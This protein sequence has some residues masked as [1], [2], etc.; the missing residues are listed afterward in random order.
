[1]QLYHTLFCRCPKIGIQPFSKTLCDLAGVPFK[2]YMATQL[3]TAFDVYCSLLQGVRDRVNVVLGRGE[4][5]WRMLNSC[6]SCQYRLKED[7]PLEIRMIVEMD[8]NDSLRRVERR[9]DS[10]LE[11][12]KEGEEEDTPR[13]GPLK[14]RPDHRVGGGSYFLSRHEVDVWDKDNWEDV[15]QVEQPHDHQKTP[16]EMLWEDGRCEERWNNMK[17][18]NTSRS[19]GRFYEWGWFILLCR[20]MFLLVACDMIRSGEQYV[21]FF[22]FTLTSTNRFIRSKY[23]LACLHKYMSAEKAQRLRNG[24]S[25]PTGKLGC[26]YDC[27]CRLGKTMSRSPLQEL[28]LWSLLLP[29]V[30][31]MHGYAHERLCQLLFLMLYIAGTGLE[32]GEGCERFFSFMNALAA[33]TRHMSV[34]HRRQAIAEVAYAHDNLEAY[35]NLSRFIYNNYRQLLDILATRNSVSRS[36]S[37]AGITPE[38]F[39]EWLEEEGNYLR[40]LTK[41]P[42][43]E[44]LEMEYY[45]KLESLS[46][47]Q[48]RLKKVREVWVEYRPS[49]KSKNIETKYRNEQENEQKLIADVQAL[50]QK[51]GLQ[52]RWL[53]GSEEWGAAKKLVAE[54]EYR[55]ALDKLEGLLVARIFEMSRLNVAGTGMYLF[56]DGSDVFD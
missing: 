36:M 31:L 42:P 24:E 43:S 12:L 45:L 16:L 35:A 23:P 52:S 18:R 4:K 11:P 26:A 41:V 46:A 48:I 13:L 33:V 2:P 19:V 5:D 44:T 32:D 39:F 25:R 9:G 30:G 7:L 1:M 55:K 3:S 54:R 51:L 10:S 20:H 47:C 34:F 14:E 28:A 29:M 56:F 22:L 15:P 21:Y 6:P 8:G 53:E 27:G 49:V 37:Q 40:S 50:E 17:E 38:N